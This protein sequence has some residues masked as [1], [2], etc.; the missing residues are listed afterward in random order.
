[1]FFRKGDHI[2]KLSKLLRVLVLGFVIRLSGSSIHL[3]NHNQ[4]LPL[5]LGTV[6][7]VS[8]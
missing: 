8:L 1:M 5:G 2:G 7:C 3:F 6:S 4:M